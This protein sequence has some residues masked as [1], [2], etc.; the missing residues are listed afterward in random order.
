MN[1][2]LKMELVPAGAWENN[3]RKIITQSHWDFIR[4]K[5]YQSTDYH[6]SVCGVYCEPGAG[7]LDA[8]EQW[9]FNPEN[10]TQTL[11][12]IIPVCKYCHSV[13]HIGRT[14]LFSDEYKERAIEQFLTVNN[15]DIDTYNDHS[16][17]VWSNYHILSQI[18]SWALNIDLI[19]EYD[20][21]SHF[22]KHCQ[23]KVKKEK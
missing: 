5:V 21:Q 1:L 20:Y 11:I 6:C 15:C 9:L 18:P 7:K 3:L 13:I 14:S 10:K 17:E 19:E 2:K 16:R 8:H 23:K 12:N 4:K 22:A